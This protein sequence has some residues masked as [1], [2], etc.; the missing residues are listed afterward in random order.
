V[1]SK[2]GVQFSAIPL[3]DSNVRQ[4]VY[5]HMPLCCHEHN[6]VPVTGQCHSL[7]GKINRGPRGEY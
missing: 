3:S 1:I 7:A 6:L 4:V 5:T 2:S